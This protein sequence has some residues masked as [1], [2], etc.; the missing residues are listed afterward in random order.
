MHGSD[1]VD[2]RDVWGMYRLSALEAMGFVE[3]K[4]G[5]KTHNLA[6][7]QYKLTDKAKQLINRSLQK[8]NDNE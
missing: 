6:F 7:N 5:G 4:V 2:I 1:W 3:R 8:E